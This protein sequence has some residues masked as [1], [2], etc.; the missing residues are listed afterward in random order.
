[1]GSQLR[2]RSSTQRGSARPRSMIRRASAPAKSKRNP[3]MQKSSHSY[4]TS[5]RNNNSP[6]SIHLLSHPAIEEPT[7]FRF[8]AQAQGH[9]VYPQTC[10]VPHQ[11]NWG[12]HGISEW[13]ASLPTMHVLSL[14]R[15]MGICQQHSELRE[16]LV[17]L[18]CLESAQVSAPC[19]HN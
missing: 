17:P 2:R 6:S 19:G 5:T 12:S 18:T 3:A 1:V 10:F 15:A 13:D 4:G 11:P 7:R 8:E 9:H 16:V 14:T